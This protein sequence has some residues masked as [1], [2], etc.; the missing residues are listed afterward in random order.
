MD[1]TGQDVMLQKSD[2]DL[3]LIMIKDKVKT[4]LK[5]TTTESAQLLSYLLSCFGMTIEEVLETGKD[6]DEVEHKVLN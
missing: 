1:Y 5:L 3:L 2:D 4:T 6:D